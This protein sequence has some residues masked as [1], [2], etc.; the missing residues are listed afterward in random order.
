MLFVVELFNLHPDRLCQLADLYR[1]DANAIALHA[2]LILLD[3]FR[4]CST[5]NLVC[6]PSERRPDAQGQGV[7]LLDVL[8]ELSLILLN[9][10]YQHVLSFFEFV[11]TPLGLQQPA[12][13]MKLL[14]LLTADMPES[15]D[16]PMPE[17]PPQA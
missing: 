11:A 10:F 4:C 6:V 9:L 1:A 12:T 16:R 13:G 3:V 5:F 14:L 8:L 15:R 7:S 2:E 17:S